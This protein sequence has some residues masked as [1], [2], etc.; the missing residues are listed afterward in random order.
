MDAAVNSHRGMQV[1]DWAAAE[2]RLHVVLPPAALLASRKLQPH[3]P[4]PRS[5]GGRGITTTVCG[6]S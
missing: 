1:A 5:L 3:V 4:G 6:Q 2:E